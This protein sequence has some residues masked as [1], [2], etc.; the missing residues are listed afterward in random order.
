MAR[1]HGVAKE[2]SGEVEEFC[3]R[4]NLTPGQRVELLQ[5]MFASTRIASGGRLQFSTRVNSYH[6][7]AAGVEGVKARSVVRKQEHGRKAGESYESVEFV[8]DEAPTEA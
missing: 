8:L 1:Y 7:I 3:S 6:I 4:H 5:L 2:I